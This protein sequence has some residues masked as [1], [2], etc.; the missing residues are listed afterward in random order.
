[1]DHIC[2]AICTYRR[3][4]LLDAC[5]ESLINQTIPEST[6]LSIVVIDND[7]E[8][9]AREIFERRRANGKLTLHYHIEERRGIPIARNRA[10]DE[11]LRLNTDWLAF[12]DDDEQA[13]PDWIERLYFFAL[14]YPPQTV[15]H[16]RVVPIFPEATPRH[17]RETFYNGR[18]RS[19]GT[20]IKRCATDNVFFPLGMI[21]DLKLRFDETYPLAGGTDSAFFHEAT[22]KGARIFECAEA[23]VYETILPERLRLRWLLA[24]KFRTGITVGDRRRR[25]KRGRL[26]L[27][28]SGS[29]K[30]LLHALAGAL[31]SAAFMRTAGNRQLMK[32]ARNTGIAAGAIGMRVD[33]YAKID[34]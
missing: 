12:I 9:S 11:A 3:A 14:K 32:A 29:A 31:C 28:A 8:A 18:I 10:L 13:H 30:A 26:V 20:E 6:A 27:V 22:R 2:V 7:V 23:V 19:S 21:S 16:G 33:S 1:M 24:R 4:R 5:L 34:G 17:L 25:E 15:V